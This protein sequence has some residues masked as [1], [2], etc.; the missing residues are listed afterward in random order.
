[1]VIFVLAIY[2]YYSSHTT[3]NE[4]KC[5][6]E[7]C[8]QLE[9]Y[10]SDV[11]G[12]L[13]LYLG[14][15]FMSCLEFIELAT[16]LVIFYTIKWIFILRYWRD[17]QKVSPSLHHKGNPGPAAGGGG[18]GGGPIS[19]APETLEA[20]AAAPGFDSAPSPTPPVYPGEASLYDAYDAPM[21]YEAALVVRR[22]RRGRMRPD[23]IREV[24]LNL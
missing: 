15:S 9:S 21:P 23:S 12:V 10:F 3:R 13:G 16:D 20:A 17:L 8:F 4:M 11:G 14:M 22:T 19:I 7:R 18:G 6:L 5:D 2:M 24:L 1:M